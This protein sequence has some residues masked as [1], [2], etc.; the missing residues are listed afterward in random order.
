LERDAQQS[1]IK[2]VLQRQRNP[3]F[4]E[5]FSNGEIADKAE[6]LVK[7]AEAM[8]EDDDPHREDQAELSVELHSDDRRYGLVEVL[9]WLLV[10]AFLARK[11]YE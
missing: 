11:E 1:E 5:S 9:G 6:C 8:D 4:E 2:R 7:L 3:A 10:M